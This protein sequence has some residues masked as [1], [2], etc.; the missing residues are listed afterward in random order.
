LGSITFND[1][2]RRAFTYAFIGRQCNGSWAIL[3][4]I[5][6]TFT[7]FDTNLCT[8][9]NYPVVDIVANEDAGSFDYYSRYMS[10]EHIRLSGW[11]I[12]RIVLFSLLGVAVACI[13]AL[14]A[15]LVIR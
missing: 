6:P 9:F 10:F 1:Q 8:Y 3:K 5:N 12:L 13:A 7:H 2:Q 15:L 4:A 14:I 11:R